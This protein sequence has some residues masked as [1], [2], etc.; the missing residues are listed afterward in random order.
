MTNDTPNDT[1]QH[2]D[3]QAWSEVQLPTGTGAKD[4]Y[5]MPA[6][7]PS[8]ADRAIRSFNVAD[9]TVPTRK[10]EDFRYTPVERLS[11]FFEPFEPS[12]ATEVSVEP[13]EGDDLPDGVEISAIDKGE[14]PMG[15]VGEPADRIEAVEWNAVEDAMLVTLR[16]EVSAPVLISVHGVDDRLDALHLVIEA[17][18]GAHADVVIDHTGLARLD[19][20]VEIIAGKDSRLN[21]TSLQQWDAGSK[22]VGG[23]RISVG[24]GAE[25]RHNVVTLGGDVVRLRI[26]QDFAG[27]QA[28]SEMLGIYFVEPGQH[29]EHRTMIV[30]NQPQCTSRVIY[31]GALAGKGAHS[32]WVGNALILP[33]APGT[34]SYELNRNLLLTRGAIADSEPNLEIENGNIVGAG[35]ASSVGRFDDEQ[36][37]YLQSRGIPENVARR[38]VVHGFFSELVEQIGLPQIS[39]ALMGSLDA[40][41]EGDAKA[42]KAAD[43]KLVEQTEGTDFDGADPDD[44]DPDDAG[45][46]SEE[47]SSDNNEDSNEPRH[48]E[49]N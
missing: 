41:L 40:R 10:Q 30:H 43:L 42:I 5:A 23:H 33:N 9:H 34:D 32:A 20:C 45:F 47:P 6:L 25:L 36:L 7:M 19:E 49:E 17:E 12:G 28:K 2:K 37:F 44:A 29:L 11:E 4:P 3:T 1:T 38:L 22:H 27:P 35:H 21:V 48:T 13:L 26:D 24:E 31:K 18:E 14:A 8:S 16:G 46:G 15:T 39:A